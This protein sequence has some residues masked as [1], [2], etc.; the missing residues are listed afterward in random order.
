MPPHFHPLKK[1]TINTFYLKSKLISNS[2]DCFYMLFVL[3]DPLNYIYIIPLY[4]E[5][6][7][8]LRYETP[9]VP[10]LF[11]KSA[12]T[13]KTLIKFKYMLLSV[14]TVS[15]YTQ[16]SM[17]A[18]S[19]PKTLKSRVLVG[20]RK[21]ANKDDDTMCNL[22]IPISSRKLMSSMQRIKFRVDLQ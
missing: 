14:R 7:I 1:C 21:A 6:C 5:G 12:K 19:A 18:Q 15:G 22:C 20:K 2:T 4:K 3:S 10:L 16:C 9:G 17:H 8:L 11:G 13:G